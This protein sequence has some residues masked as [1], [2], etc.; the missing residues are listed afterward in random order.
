LA[1]TTGA[2]AARAGV[3]KQTIYRWWPSKGAVILEAFERLAA[4]IPVPDTGDL[5]SDLRA[6][7][8]NVVRLFNDE[9]FGRAGTQAGR[10]SS[11]T[12]QLAKG[13]PGRRLLKR[14]RPSQDRF[15]PCNWPR[16][17]RRAH[18][19][20]GAAGP[21]GRRHP[22]C[23]QTRPCRLRGER[24]LRIITRIMPQI[25]SRRHVRVRRGSPPQRS[26]L[27]RRRRC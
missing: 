10:R 6:F 5:A 16:S 2:I 27:R 21:S 12:L 20:L 24:D 22:R 9:N 13:A 14:P 17:E 11:R 23:A 3:G 18:P 26:A 7:L 19:P 25:G 8:I 15:T 4:E 1:G